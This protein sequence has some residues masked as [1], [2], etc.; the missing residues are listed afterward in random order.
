MT[1]SL[2]CSSAMKPAIW[3]NDLQ[4]KR[5]TTIIEHEIGVTESSKSK[6]V[7]KKV[8]VESLIESILEYPAI[9]NYAVVLSGS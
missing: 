8:G 7:F 1:T 5:Y 2:Q 9:P 3:H 6:S 4:F